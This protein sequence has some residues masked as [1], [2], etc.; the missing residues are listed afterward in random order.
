MSL[1]VVEQ[2]S[3]LNQIVNYRNKQER[4][5]FALLASTVLQEK[6][7]KGRGRR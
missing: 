7:Y 4:G 2:Y 5:I 1:G 6:V 3:I